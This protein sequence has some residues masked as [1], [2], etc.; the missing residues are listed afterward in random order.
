M[1]LAENAICYVPQRLSTKGALAVPPRWRAESMNN[2]LTAQVL[3]DTYG[4]FGQS[5]YI[6]SY[7][8]TIDADDTLMIRISRYLELYPHR[9]ERLT[10]FLTFVILNPQSTHISDYYLEEARRFA[11]WDDFCREKQKQF[12]RNRLLGKQLLP[13]ILSP[14][15]MDRRDFMVPNYLS[16]SIGQ[17]GYR[18]PYSKP[19][20]RT[21]EWV[22]TPRAATEATKNVR[23]AFAIDCEMVMC[24][25]ESVLAQICA[26]DFFSESVVY[27]TYVIP[28]REVTDYLV[29]KSGIS[30]DDLSGSTKTLAEVQAVLLTLFQDSNTVLI[31]HSLHN[32]LKALK[33]SHS[34]VIDTALVF[35]HPR[36][37]NASTFDRPSLKWCAKTWLNIDV[38][39]GSHNP[40]E[41]ANTCI[42]LIKEKIK[43]GPTFGKIS[44]CSNASPDSPYYGCQSDRP[45]E[46]G[47]IGIPSPQPPQRHRSVFGTKHRSHHT[48]TGHHKTRSLGTGS[49]NSWHL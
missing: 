35:D 41:D 8:Q 23:R 30:R 6:H 46:W 14:T 5:L 32:D 49:S 48:K 39:Q 33:L 16:R 21:A 25:D 29:D 31:G 4:F 42:K 44:S 40:V 9:R 27:N 2:M 20:I 47:S 45:T 36:G 1:H 7:K 34:R 10:E 3:A 13:F 38:Q 22:E 37:K 19:P 28:P 18:G 12:R 43:R 15:E 17:V 24:G 26:V 11:Q